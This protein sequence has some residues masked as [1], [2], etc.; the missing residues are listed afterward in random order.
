M[1]LWKLV[2]DI[3][4]P[5]G[6]GCLCCDALSGGSLLCPTCK[7]ALEAVRLTGEDAGI[8]DIRSIYSYDGNAKQLVRMLKEDCL[9]DAAHVLAEAMVADIKELSLPENTVL[10]WVTMPELRRKKR[11]IDHGRVLC[12]AVAA[13]AELPVKQLLTRRKTL[14]TQRGL[15]REAR[16]K[17]ISGSIC[18]ENQVDTAVLIIDDVLTT[19]ATVH[20]CADALMRAGATKVYALTAT[21]SVLKR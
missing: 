21:R 6:V 2:E 11:G 1:R 17:N 15:N 4:W 9:A 5:R 14:H 16:L 18:C 8:G 7:N 10:T 13:Q 3:L 12:E 19:G 20:A